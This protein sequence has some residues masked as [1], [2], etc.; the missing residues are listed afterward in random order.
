MKASIIFNRLVLMLAALLAAAWPQAT[1]ATGNQR[2]TLPATVTKIH[3]NHECVGLFVAVDAAD[4]LK[5]EPSTEVPDRG[6]QD[7]LV[8]VVL[9]PG[10]ADGLGAVQTAVWPEFSKSLRFEF[11]FLSASSSAPK[12]ALPS[13]LT[14]VDKPA[15]E[16]NG[17]SRELKF[18][19]KDVPIQARSGTLVMT[20][21]TS[22]TKV[23]EVNLNV[24]S[25]RSTKKGRRKMG[26]V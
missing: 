19:V 9:T 7:V 12:E 22:E 17:I 1:S 11:S 10:C 8:Q 5:N 24:P 26:S 18:S 15:W 25:L 2:K 6:K 3:Y 23:G 21:F 14:S 4:N 20:I 13:D 16:E